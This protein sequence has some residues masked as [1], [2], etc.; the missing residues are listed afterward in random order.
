[1]D[2]EHNGKF[3]VAFRNMRIEQQ[4]FAAGFAILMLKRLAPNGVDQNRV[5]LIRA[6]EHFFHRDFVRFDSRSIVSSN[7]V[8]SPDSRPDRCC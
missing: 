2:D 5:P 1:M 8:G 3:P 7:P 6:A 4:F